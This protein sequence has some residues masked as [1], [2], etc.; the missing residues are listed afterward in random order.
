MTKLNWAN[1]RKYSGYEQ[2]FPAHGPA[3]HELAPRNRF[4]AMAF[5]DAERDSASDPGFGS[6]KKR[7]GQ[8]Y[9]PNILA[10]AYGLKPVKQKRRKKAESQP[11]KLAMK[12]TQSTHSKNRSRYL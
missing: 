10:E 9:H 7:S 5:A 3:P 11:A 8:S 4:E 2:A 1:A 12:K 6:R